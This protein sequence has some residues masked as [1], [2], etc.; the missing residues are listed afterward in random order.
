MR[1]RAFRQGLAKVAT[2]K[3]TFTATISKTDKVQIAKVI[4]NACVIRTV[5]EQFS[6]WH[7]YVF[8]DIV[9]HVTRL[10]ERYAW[11][12]LART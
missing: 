11:M 6:Q 3:Q 5:F 2:G 10:Y 12:V 9:G 7:G 1:V 4:G 8:V